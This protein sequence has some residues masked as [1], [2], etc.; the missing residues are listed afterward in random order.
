MSIFSNEFLISKFFI[1][2]L[3]FSNI[4]CFFVI[5]FETIFIKDKT[6]NNADYFTNLTQTELV[7]NFTIG[8][9]NP[10]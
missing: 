5:P 8:S 10:S 7:I 2:Y 1:I 9:K 3:F 6:I 4:N